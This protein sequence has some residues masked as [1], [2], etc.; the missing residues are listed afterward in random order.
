ML[1]LCKI[2]FKINSKGAYM[3]SFDAKSQS[4]S[5]CLESSSTVFPY[6]DLLA[7]PL[8]TGEAPFRFSAHDERNR[9]ETDQFAV[10]SDLQILKDLIN[11]FAHFTLLESE[12]QL[13]LCDLQG[14]FPS[15]ALCYM[16]HRANRPI[17]LRL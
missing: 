12:G 2:V 15:N 8:L 7:T 17:Y 5:G 14:M 9:N 1:I 16:L 11:E 6:L 13:L 4:V 3:A 10:D